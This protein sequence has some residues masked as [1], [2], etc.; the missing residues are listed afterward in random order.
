MAIKKDKIKLSK[1]IP[2]NAPAPRSGDGV[3]PN[4]LTNPIRRANT[5]DVGD[6][7]PS[8]PTP[9]F[10]R[11]MFKMTKDGR[12]NNVI[13]PRF[14]DASELSYLLGEYFATKVRPVI[15]DDG[16]FIGYKWV[17]KVSVSGLANWL[18]VHADTL[19]NVKQ[20][21]E[22]H[23]LLVMAKQIIEE[24]NEQLLLD[25][26]NPGGVIFMLKNNFGWKDTQDV[27]VSQKSPFEDIKN[28]EEIRKKLYNSLGLID[29]TPT[30]IK[31]NVEKVEE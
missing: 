17:Q 11:D 22:Y 19:R 10:L 31:E 30:E 13:R 2:D 26:R 1:A 16:Y 29:I 24:Y 12:T 4:L 8:A 7:P 3:L 9:V 23:E 18:H 15:D 6:S 28:P 27:I 5:K 20:K 14:K 21:D 25:N